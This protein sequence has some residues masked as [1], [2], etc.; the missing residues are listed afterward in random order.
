M[1]KL[2]ILPSN[3]AEK[4]W[5]SV[6]KLGCLLGDSE[7]VTH[8]KKKAAAAIIYL[9]KVWYSRKNIKIDRKLKICNALVLPCLTYNIGTLVLTKSELNSLDAFHQKQ[10]RDVWRNQRLTNR[11]VYTKCKARPIHQDMKIARRWRILG[12]N[13]RL[14]TDTPSQRAMHYY[15]EPSMG[16]KMFPG[17]PRMAIATTNNQGKH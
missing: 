10:L 12:H 13:L 2:Y 11:Q 3:E 16:A 7:E 5:R 6:K 8:R 17:K 9:K 15:M 1:T 4:V 14:P